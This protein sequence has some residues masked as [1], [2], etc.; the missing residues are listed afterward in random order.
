[1]PVERRGKQRAKQKASTSKAAAVGRR[2]AAGV[3]RAR[4]RALRRRERAI[5]AA[6]AKPIPRARAQARPQG[7]L[8]RPRFVGAAGSR[9][10]ATLVAEGDSWFDYP[11]RDILDALESEH[12]Y[13]VESVAHHGD[14]VEDMAYGEKQYADFSRAIEKMLRRQELPKAILFSGGGN[15]IAGD[16]FFMLLDHA[17]SASPGANEDVVRGVIDVRIRN[18]YVSILSAVT[19][20]CVEKTG[21]ALPI[22]VHGYGYAVPDGRGFLGGWWI[23]P[24]PWLRPGFVRKGL[25]DLDENRRTLV[26]LIDRFNTMLEGVA[27][28]PLFPHVHF[29]DLRGL[30]PNGAGYKR[31]WA[32]ELHPTGRGFE[33]VARRFAEVI[34][35]LP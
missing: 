32:D 10:I 7:L 12:G 6:R 27:A 34:A 30:L 19:K 20:L 9:G 18:A 14:R 35:K 24:G 21:H 17:R 28:A 33:A 16:E 8:V 22:L 15:D 31:W 23:L 13:D 26:T 25:L 3:G 5:T 2:I 4:E 11:G 29:V 1:M